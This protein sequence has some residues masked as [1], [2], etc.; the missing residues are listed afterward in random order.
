MP[1]Y[2]CKASSIPD[3]DLPE[4]KWF[5]KKSR[6]LCRTC[7]DKLNDSGYAKYEL[8]WNDKYKMYNKEDDEWCMKPLKTQ[9]AVM[10]PGEPNDTTKRSNAD[11]TTKPLAEKPGE[12]PGK[13]TTAAERHGVLPPPPPPV[14]TFHEVPPPPSME[15]AIPVRG[16]ERSRSSRSKPPPSV[17]AAS[18][19]HDR[20]RSR[21]SRSNSLRSPRRQQVKTF[22][23]VSLSPSMEAARGRSAGAGQRPVP[24]SP[25]RQ[26]LRGQRGLTLTEATCSSPE[27]N[28]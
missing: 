4:C 26:Q 21:S 7:H 12:V 24:P 25:S 2:W 16:R 5:R 8:W 15:A 28:T 1:Y 13:T 11:D 27:R 9:V 10:P 17:E 20:E 3:L 22:H 19:V 23:E 18:P 6:G 14:K